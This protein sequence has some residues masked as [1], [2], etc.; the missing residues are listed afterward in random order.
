VVE[1][2]AVETE[3]YSGQIEAVDKVEIRPRV[4]GY[5][6]SVNFRPGALVKKGDV[7]FVIDA[8]P[9]QAEAKRA[10]AAM[11]AARAKADLASTELAR[12]KKLVVEKAIAQRELDEKAAA[13][14]EFEAQARGAQAAYEAA[15]LNLSYTR[16][17][18][19]INGRV[20]KAELTVGNLVD[21]GV[22]LTSVVGSNPLYAS[23]EASQAAFLQVG[24]DVRAGKA[25]AVRI[26]AADE[27]GFARE[28]IL[29]FVDN[30][31]DPATGTVRMRA[32]V[33]NSDNRLAP[34]VFARVQLA[35]RGNDGNKALVV[36]ERAISTDQDRKFVFVVGADG[37]A[38]YRQVHLGPLMGSLRIVRGGLKA[39]ERIVV[40]GLQ[41]VRPGALIAPQ[42]AGMD[43]RPLVHAQTAPAGSDV[44]QR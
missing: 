8:R 22:V 20:S 21:S 17:E 11:L 33:D 15:R 28:G 4:S 34:G 14:Q 10:E 3:E 31:I 2:T 5:I 1:Q 37:K 23:F 26:A 44:V 40:N 32:R 36:A 30:Q 29:E 24:H 25:V 6:A 12:A 27:S 42:I 16:V 38:E 18:S 13:Y 9:F 7:L 35:Q 19:P 41:R 39:G 43:G